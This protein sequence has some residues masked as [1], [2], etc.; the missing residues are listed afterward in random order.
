MKNTNQS[1]RSIQS[2]VIL[3][4][5]TGMFSFCVAQQPA[6]ATITD[7]TAIYRLQITRDTLVREETK[8][9]R[10]QDELN[11]QIWDLKRQNDPSFNF[12][13]ND[14]S[15]RLDDTYTKLQKTRWQL[16]QVQNALL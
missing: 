4:V 11:H 14:L 10:D 16:R 7:A 6:A 1:I 5:L 2:L 3:T 15:N 12:Q 8:L 13:L 9:L